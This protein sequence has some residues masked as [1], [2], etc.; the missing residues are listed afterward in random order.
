MEEVP[1]FGEPIDEIRLMRERMNVD[2][3]SLFV[4]PALGQVSA[5]PAARRNQR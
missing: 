3:L 1:S 5:L 4:N 2:S